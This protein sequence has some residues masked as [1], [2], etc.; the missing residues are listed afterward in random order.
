MKARIGVAE[1]DKVVEVEIDDLDKFKKSV[2]KAVEGGGLFW[3]TDSKK[4]EV[5]IPAKSIAF[6]EIDAADADH[7]VGFAPA[8]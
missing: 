4:R 3:F 2:E 1:T 7:A 8:V 5:G 6:V